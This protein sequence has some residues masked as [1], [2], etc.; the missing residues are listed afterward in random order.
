MP[1]DLRPPHPHHEWEIEQE[2]PDMR[3][4]NDSPQS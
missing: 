4:P 3:A 2:W 1:L